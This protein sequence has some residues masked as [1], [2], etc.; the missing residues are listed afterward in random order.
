M[1]DIAMCSGVTQEG[2]VCKMKSNCYRHTATPNANWQ[3]YMNCP[4]TKDETCKYFWINSRDKEILK[5][6]NNQVF[7]EVFEAYMKGEPIQVYNGE[8][9][10]W[11]DLTYDVSLRKDGF[12]YRIK[13]N[14]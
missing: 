5:C 11:F 9:Q 14:Q 4:L 8:A 12:A 3:T 1:A 2:K 6:R 13:P 10:D 7:K